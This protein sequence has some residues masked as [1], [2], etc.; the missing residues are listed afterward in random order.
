MV[1]TL[2][3]IGLIVSANILLSK[4]KV[5]GKSY[6]GIELKYEMIDMVARARVNLNMLDSDL[7]TQIPIKNHLYLIVLVDYTNGGLWRGKF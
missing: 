7:K 2:A 5:G 4:V 3:F 6:N 1:I